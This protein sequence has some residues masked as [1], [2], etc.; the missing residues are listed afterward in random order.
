MTQPDPDDGPREPAPG[1]PP[2]RRRSPLEAWLAGRA[3]WLRAYPGRVRE[4]ARRF[5]ADWRAT[6]AGERPRSAAA[7]RRRPR[8][9][10]RGVP[11][12]PG[13]ATVV[14]RREDDANSIIGRIEAAS[15]VEVLVVVPRRARGLR[16]PMAWPRIAAHARQRGLTVRVLAS[17]RDVRQHALEAGLST[18]R[19]PRGLRPA[20]GVTIP[21]G[22]RELTLRLPSPAPLLRLAAFAA[23]PVVALGTAAY[24]VPSAD[25]YIAPPGEPLS[26]SMRVRLNPVGETDVAAGVI[27]ATS[28]SETIAA[29]VSTVSTGTTSVGDT[30]AT[31][32]LF[33]TNTGIA[34]ATLP[35][36]TTVDDEG[37]YTFTTD[38]TITIPAAGSATV[39]ATAVKPGAAGNLDAGALRFLIGLPETLEVTNPLA[40]SGGE[41]VDVPAASADDVVRV[42]EI[43]EEV[44]RRA[45]ARELERLVE[46]GRVFA[47]TVTVAILSQEPLVQPGEPSDAFMMEYTAV[48]SALVLTDDDARRAGEQLLVSVL[49][50]NEALLPGST[51]VVAASPS[52]DGSRLTATLTATGLVTPLFDPATLRGVLTGVAPATA[53]ARLREQLALDVE[54]LIRVHPGLLPAWR[55]PQREDRISIVFLTEED[56]AAEIAGLPDEGEE[57]E[58]GETTDGD[59]GDE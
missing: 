10:P 9:V 54:P 34:D 37:G 38:E 39:G 49:A 4:E 6:R 22:T 8:N 26:T 23:I 53:A 32:E 7:R 44:L 19:T 18:A 1:A 31:V 28:I 41:D 25:I 27:G 2:E 50:D 17:R 40:A 21:L 13:A 24:C 48:V 20:P 57:G 59:T 52:W 51:Q 56:L 14:A 43:A 11:T 35:V 46:D 29:V 5:V 47:E 15:E 3:E 45:G 30:P 12:L 58:D 55:M 42:G 16:D 33:F 36:G